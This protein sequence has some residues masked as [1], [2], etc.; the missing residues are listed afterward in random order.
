MLINNICVAISFFV[1][2]VALIP[3]DCLEYS[4]YRKIFPMEIL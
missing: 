4:F 2:T 1:L 3:P